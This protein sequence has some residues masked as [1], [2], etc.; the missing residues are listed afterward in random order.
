MAK[1]QQ[2]AT[3]KTT[4][5]TVRAGKGGAA[6]G[7]QKAALARLE[8]ERDLPRWVAP[9]VFAL[10][11]VLLFPEVFFQHN[12]LFGSDTLG[13]SYFARNFYTEF[14]RAHHAFPLWDPM[15]LGGLP[16][17][18]GMH[19]DIFYPPTLALFFLS[20]KAMW[21]WKMVLHVFLA[22]VFAYIW[23]RRGMK[24]RRGPSL[25]GG[26]VFMMGA[27]LVSLVAPGGDG[28]LF[29][30]ALAPL[31][32]WLA[33]R[34][35]SGRR[36]ADFAGFALG[37]TLIVLTSH[38]QLAYFCIWG[39]TFY[40][41]FRVWEIWRT[42]RDGGEAARLIGMFALAG[43][44]GVG[45]AAIQFLPPLQYVKA[46]SLR[47]DART[48]AADTYEEATS[49]S[50]HPEE[51]MSL[52]VPE[53]VGA[54]DMGV[55]NGKRNAPTY[56]GRNGFKLNHEY[57]GA[58]AL[59]LLPVM[60]LRRRRRVVWFF[61]GLS[62]FSL[63][64]AV[65]ATTPLFHLF[66]LIPGVKLFRAPSL[67]IFLYA[68]SISTLGA[69]AV[70]R[71]LEWRGGDAADEEAVT[72]YFWI[73]LGVTGFLAVLATSG[74]LMKIWTGAIYNPAGYDDYKAAALTAN[75]G[76]IQVG[77][78]I[79]FAMTGLLAAWWAGL[80]K[81]TLGATA[82][83]ALVTVLAAV[84]LYRVDRPF[85]KH[86]AF[87]NTQL[88]SI[89]FFT[90]DTVLTY[91][92]NQARDPK[93]VFRV[94]NFHTGQG[95][96]AYGFSRNALAIHGIEQVAGLHGNEIGRYVNVVGVDATGAFNNLKLLDLVNAEYL[97][98]PGQIQDIPQFELVTASPNAVLYRNKTA[99]PRAFL[100]GSAQVTRDSIA[101]DAMRRMMFDPR[102]VVL[103][104]EKMEALNVLQGDAFGSVE[105]LEHSPNRLRMR[106]TSSK[107]GVLVVTDNYYPA[108][109]AT[110]GGKPAAVFRADY[111]FRGVVVPAGTTDVEMYYSTD[112]MRFAAIT[113]VV[114]M[115][116]LLGACIGGI[117]RPRE[118]AA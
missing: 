118:E 12:T 106:V 33:E 23:L 102:R 50:L 2:K 92:Q 25:F 94:A 75:M 36:I 68:L 20:A 26:V 9:I 10:A 114:L 63:L 81:A 66:I 30:S 42:N 95:E 44:L 85:V 24:L 13:L 112:H 90:A 1:R 111:T 14:V 97:L 37:I 54:T 31:V 104:P 82:A 80:R 38:M 72:R 53:F 83:I 113:S 51:V 7:A 48:T 56:W 91:L 49:Y 29:V 89:P 61:A 47:A 116:L 78:W 93:H 60:F 57:A 109:K 108:W 67:I 3:A 16:F 87:S 103:V 84:D 28:K 77:F 59:L 18:E 41:F 4:R 46:T 39:V 52:A 32:F 6:S 100:V 110:V 58:I 5:T 101:L 88:T 11:T 74:I 76:R 17:L 45:A 55:E 107:P 35:V 71:L 22:G 27:D 73:A 86:T 70:Q 65:G 15:V 19:G 34:A 117:V 99:M 115:L 105:W 98:F 21:A 40:F 43:L 96:Y 8:A 69:M 64:F 62:I 79:L